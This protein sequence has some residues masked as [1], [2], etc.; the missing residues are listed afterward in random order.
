[1]VLGWADG[2]K[3]RPVALGD[4]A[5]L[6]DGGGEDAW[7]LGR[8]LTRATT[9]VVRGYDGDVELGDRAASSAS[10]SGEWSSEGGGSYGGMSSG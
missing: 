6:R 4:V 9:G 3:A 2:A 10:T 7:Q 8:P 5:A 1:M